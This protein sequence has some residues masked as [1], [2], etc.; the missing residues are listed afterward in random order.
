MVDIEEVWIKKKIETMTL[1]PIEYSVIKMS[2]FSKK[3]FIY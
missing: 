1:N 3:M 2:R